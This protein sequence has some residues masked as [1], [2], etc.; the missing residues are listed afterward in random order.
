M[1]PPSPKEK[2]PDI[3]VFAPDGRVF[4][5]CKVRARLSTEERASPVVYRKKMKVRLSG[6][7]DLILK[8]SD[9]L[10]DLGSPTLVAVNV[11][12]PKTRDGDFE[13]KELRSTMEETEIR[14]P[15][16]NGI[17]LVADRVSTN[18][19][20]EVIQWG[21]D[22]H[23]QMNM[24]NPERPNPSEFFRIILNPAITTRPPTLMLTKYAMTH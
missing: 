11:D 10:R 16:V 15:H 24:V 13:L 19:A 8:A 4:V 18:P 22:L 2:R 20:T 21:Q 5:E 1:L 6:V 9:Q 3:E 23:L 17:L 7:K 14:R 12:L